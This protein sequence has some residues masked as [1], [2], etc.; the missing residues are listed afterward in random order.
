MRRFLD[1]EISQDAQQ[2]RPDVDA[3]ASREAVQPLKL[4]KYRRHQ[5]LLKVRTRTSAMLSA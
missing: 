2:G 4:G 5:V 1:V 3:I